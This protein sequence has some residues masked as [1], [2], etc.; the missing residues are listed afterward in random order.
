MVPCLGWPNMTTEESSG[1]NGEAPANRGRI[2]GAW[3]D[4]YDGSA[5]QELFSRLGELDFFNWILLFGATLLLT[6]LP[7]IVLLGSF[8]SERVDG[9]IARHV[10]LNRQGSQ[11]VASL[12][13]QS[14]VK[15]DSGIV[16]SLILGAAGVVAM[17]IT[18]QIIYEKAFGHEHHRSV[19]NVL[20]CSVWVAV[21]GALLIAD[22]VL[23]REVRHS[24][25]RPEVSGLVDLVGLILFFWW[26][27]H[28]LLAGRESWRSVFRAALT[29][30]V[31]WI[32]LG[33]FSAFY[34]SS[35]IVSD[36]KLYGAVGVVVDLVTWFIAVGAVM[37]LG[38]VVG[39]VWENRRSRSPQ[40][41]SEGPTKANQS[42]ATGRP[43]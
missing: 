42:I 26:S 14:T 41:A 34:F 38:A 3:H 10:G 39:A 6:V 23:S 32:G 7:I 27:I 37:M 18:L 28:F 16:V 33:V 1:T 31:F 29:T 24:P 13:K 22:G 20:R 19:G 35:S 25:L 36:D 11:A 5:A 12:F 9:D 43:L 2:A 15:F 30:A 17:A 21:L 4:H 40:P 8:A